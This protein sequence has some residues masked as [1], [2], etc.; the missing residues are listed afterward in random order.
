[1]KGFDFLNINS[2]IQHRNKFDLSMPHLTTMSIGQIQPVWNASAVPGDHFAVKGRMFSRM[3]PLMVPTY[4]KLDLKSASF[5]V[6]Y[7]QIA[8]DADAFFNGR[9]TYEGQTVYLRYF[10][11]N[12]LLDFFINGQNVITNDYVSAAVSNPAKSDGINIDPSEYDF[13][14]TD[15]SGVL[16]PMK[17]TSYGR[18]CYKFLASLGYQIPS[19]AD[20][21]E[22]E[23]DLAKAPSSTWYSTIGVKKLNA[24]PLLCA[25]KAYNDWMSNSVKY[26]NSHLSTLLLAI[27]QNKALTAQPLVGSYNG[28]GELTT[29]CLKYFFSYIRLMYENNYFT[30]SWRNAGTVDDNNGSLSRVTEIQYRPSSASDT[31]PDNEIKST[32]YGNILHYGTNVALSEVSQRGLDFLRAFDNWVR[33]NNYAGSRAVQQIYARFGIKPDYFKTHYAEV[34]STSVASM[35]VGD[36]MATTAGSDGISV[37]VLGEYAGK[38]IVSGEFGFDHTASDFGQ[39]ITLAWISV[40]ALYPFGFDRDVLRSEPLDFFTPEFDGL[41]GDSISDMEV[42]VNPKAT[43]STYLGDDTFGFTER[44]NDYRCP[45]PRVTGDYRLYDTMS[46]WHFGRDMSEL[47][48]YTAQ[49]DAVMYYEQGNTQYNRIFNITDGSVDPFYTTW[50]FDVNAVRPLKNFNQVPDLGEGDT[51]VPKNGNVIN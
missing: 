20:L 1:M 24:M 34:L 45:R 6:P 4:G 15:E 14:Y 2:A 31:Y 38:G 27:R 3:A 51:R 37:N 26:D 10:T 29:L 25:V 22:S 21:T 13:C 40:D 44:Y 12:T 39:Y 16:T 28:D 41:S 32:L 30:S 17:L 47:T 23:G 5:F 9:T 46:A 7:H 48:G 36:V 8:E 35:N 19:K 42:Y 50:W 33:R 43:D 18:W 49:S 11:V